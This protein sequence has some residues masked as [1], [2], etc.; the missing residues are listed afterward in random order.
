MIP[1]DKKRAKKLENIHLEACKSYIMPRLNFV[2]D[3]FNAIGNDVFLNFK[4]DAE[5]RKKYDNLDISSY[6]SILKSIT[7]N[8]IDYPSLIE[9]FKRGSIS[10]YSK[11][12][13]YFK[14]GHL[15]FKDMNIDNILLK[16][17]EFLHDEYVKK[18][19]NNQRKY[20]AIIEKIF[21][22]ETFTDDGFNSKT[23]V[24]WNSYKLTD[25][26][27]V[28]VCPYCNKNWTNTVYNDKGEKVTNPQLDHFF[29]KKKYPILRLSLYNLIPSCE[30]CNARIK[31]EEYLPIK[32]YINPYVEGFDPDFLIIPIAQNYESSQ[33]LGNEFIIMLEPNDGSKKFKRV[34]NSFNFFHINDV[35][36][37]HGDIIAEIHFKRIKYGIFN[38]MDLLNLPMF[39]GMG[40]EEAY[41]FVFGN[42]YEVENYN[43]RPFSKLTKD[44]LTYLDMI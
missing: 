36:E 23:L 2:I 40:I 41:R 16:N 10:Y 3:L 13:E 7:S 27:Q 21:N 42:Y 44:T 22:Y 38:V 15:F 43:K 9:S 31:K 14:K 35:Y 1:I 25:L 17:P 4:D 18:N 24:R 19:K 12:K 29:P 37:M 8:D 6:R 34:E 28:H 11:N 32:D 30:T 26:L 5:L 39:K 33:G 20:K